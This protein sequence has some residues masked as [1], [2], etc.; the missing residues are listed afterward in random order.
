MPAITQ[1]PVGWK[2]GWKGSGVNAF[3]YWLSAIRK[4]LPEPT[5]R[6]VNLSGANLYGLHIRGRSTDRRLNLVG[7][8]F[9]GC[10]LR[11]GV[12]FENA[13]LTSASFDNVQAEF[14]E[15]LNTRATRLSIDQADLSGTLWRRSECSQLKDI[16]STN[17]SGTRWLDCQTDEATL[18]SLT[19]RNVQISGHSNPHPDDANVP[20]N[21]STLQGHTA[22]V[23][24]CSFS[25]DG[26]RIVSASADKSL[27]L[28][29]ARTGECRVTLLNGQDRQQAAVD[30][31]NN[32][33]LWAG[34]EAWRLLRWRYTDPD[35]GEPR[36]LP[37]EHFGPLPT[38]PV[39]V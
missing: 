17:L 3:H 18:K 32:R 15:F 36:I 26:A 8:N 9:S 25:P 34:E 7:A 33:I 22:A 1:R 28:W 12:R 29:D 21:L 19:T 23:W 13:D 39:A 35:T 16:A 11:G 37:A 31:T 38:T 30:F 10:N 27:R 4:N 14:A 6:H 20:A 24:S 2:G 5:P